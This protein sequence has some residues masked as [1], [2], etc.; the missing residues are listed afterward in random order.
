MKFQNYVI[1]EEQGLA[2]FIPKI[3]QECK[4]FIRDIKGATGTLFRVDNKNWD[5]PVWKKKV[6]KN[7]RP[8]DTPEELHKGID[9]LFQKKFGWKAR[10]QAI[11]CW[12]IPFQYNV[13]ILGK[14]MVFPT[15]NYKYIWSKEIQDLWAYIED[16]SYKAGSEAID[17]FQDYLLD[18]YINDKIK[19]SLK[20]ENEI[21]I[22]SDYAYLIKPELME[23]V[24]EMLGLNWQGAEF[25]G[26]RF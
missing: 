5:K 19:L 3:Q 7:R 1:E 17:Y 16:I 13:M 12:S 2:Y 22:K 14:W 9:E 18:T 15:G 8:T 20:Y 23:R 11:F 25:K 24:N 6:R 26:R 4:P 10:S 21:M